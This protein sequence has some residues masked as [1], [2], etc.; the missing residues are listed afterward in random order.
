MKSILKNHEKM[1]PL[2]EP[3]GKLRKL[4]PLF[5]AQ[6]TFMF[7]PD[8]VTRN[9]PHVRDALDLKRTMSTVI[10]ALLP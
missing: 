10:L 5:E 8:E 4:Y 1:K 9:G 2:F 3:G 6:D 7:T